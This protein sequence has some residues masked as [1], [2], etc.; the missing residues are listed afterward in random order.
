MKAS[1]VD[2]RTKSN[3]ILLALNRNEQITILYRGKPTAI[4]LPIGNASESAGRAKEHP[5]FGLWADRKELKDVPSHVRQL[6][7]GRVF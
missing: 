3:E 2:L 6:R 4:M 5:A 1:F 7:E